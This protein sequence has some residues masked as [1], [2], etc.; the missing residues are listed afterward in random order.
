MAMTT[1]YSMSLAVPEIWLDDGAL[2][3]LFRYC[4]YI[5]GL[6][7]DLLLSTKP[8]RHEAGYVTASFDILYGEPMNFLG[9]G[10]FALL[11]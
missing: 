10:G 3:M 9:N 2:T 8:A 1:S 7:C 6:T 11:V 5:Y 4:R